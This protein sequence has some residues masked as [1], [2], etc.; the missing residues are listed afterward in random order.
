MYYTLSA[1]CILYSVCTPP[2][3][4][5][6]IPYVI[7]SIYILVYTVYGLSV[8]YLMIALSHT[9]C[10]GHVY[11]VLYCYMDIYILCIYYV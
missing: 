4:I 5:C 9:V 1:V 11:K 3:G 6:I 2:N 7:Y 10:I 8:L